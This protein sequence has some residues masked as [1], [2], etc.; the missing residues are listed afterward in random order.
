MGPTILAYGELWVLW[1][2][3]MVGKFRTWLGRPNP[4]DAKK[5]GSLEDHSHYPNVIPNHYANNCNQRY[6]NCCIGYDQRSSKF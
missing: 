1:N 5:L 2:M 4:I 6:C 3:L